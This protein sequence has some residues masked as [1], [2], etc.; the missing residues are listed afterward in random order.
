MTQ[1][2]SRQHFQMLSSPRKV[3]WAAGDSRLQVGGS[4][5]SQSQ[6]NPHNRQ[7]SK[8]HVPDIFEVLG[9][10]LLTLSSNM[11]TLT[12]SNV[13]YFSFDI[14][15]GLKKRKPS[16]SVPWCLQ[17]P[18]IYSIKVLYCCYIL[19]SSFE[20]HSGSTRKK[21]EDPTPISWRLKSSLSYEGQKAAA[22]VECP[23]RLF[24]YSLPTSPGINLD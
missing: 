14:P 10:P 16:V 3:R 20:E 18:Q 8:A 24:S 12:F 2:N 7:K 21:R 23:C 5:S 6:K 19:N 17:P 11:C 1:E 4:A 15:Y 9:F 22:L 13:F